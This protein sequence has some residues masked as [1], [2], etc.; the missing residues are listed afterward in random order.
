M[1]P[2]ARHLRWPQGQAWLALSPEQ[3]PESLRRPLPRAPRAR[4][5][6]AA[7]AEGWPGAVAV[8]L[9]SWNGSGG[10]FFAQGGAVFTPQAGRELEVQIDAPEEDQRPQALEELLFDGIA[11]LEVRPAGVLALSRLT[12]H[13]VDFKAWAWRCCGATLARLL[14]AD[15][16]HQSDEDLLTLVLEVRLQ[17]TAAP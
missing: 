17:V 14:C 3:W 4:R 13:P 9:A 15:V 6:F 8:R 11:A 7:T 5:T 16:L 1:Q 10:S 2:G 12:V